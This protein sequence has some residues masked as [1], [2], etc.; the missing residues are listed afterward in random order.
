MINLVIPTLIMATI[1]L[2]VAIAA[3]VL[4]L[5]QKFSTHKIEWKPIELH[6]LSEEDKFKEEEDLQLSKEDE[7]LANALSLSK[8]AKKK[9]DEDPL[10][11]ILETN[12][13]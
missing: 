6:G 8:K 3:L 12:N 9:R 4:V 2:V 11:E 13:F 10:D 1:S 5:A 7:F